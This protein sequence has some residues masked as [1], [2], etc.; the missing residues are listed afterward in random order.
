MPKFIPDS[1]KP[2]E[3]D[4]Q[5][6]MEKYRITREE[7]DRQIEELRDHEFRRS[8]TDWNRV[9]RNWFRTAEK[10]ELLKRE[11]TYRKPEEVSDEQRY[12]DQLKFEE[13]M[14]RLGVSTIGAK[15]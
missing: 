9:F 14:K 3:K 13:D 11:R 1:F 7:V 15:R 6:A 8:Y 5:W 2:R 10:Y 4:I 12:Q